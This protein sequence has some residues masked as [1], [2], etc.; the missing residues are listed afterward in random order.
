MTKWRNDP[1]LM[2]L[3]I[4]L[5]V[6]I[7][8][9]GPFGGQAKQP[10]K[11]AAPTEQAAPAESGGAQAPAPATK[12][13]LPTA[14]ATEAPAKKV[15][16]TPTSLNNLLSN[17]VK[18]VPVHVTTIYTVYE[19][20]RVQDRAHMEIDIDAAGNRHIFVYSGEED[21]QQAEIL[22][23]DKA[24]FMRGS[25][26]DQYL[27]VPMQ[28][29][30]EDWTFL[31]MYGAPWFLFFN[32]VENASKVGA[33]TVNGFSTD[34]Y[35][36]KFNMTN[37]GPLGAAAALQGGMFDYKGTG[38]IEKNSRALVKAAVSLTGKGKQDKQPTT[39]Q[40][41]FDVKKASVAPIKKPDNVFSAPMMP[42]PGS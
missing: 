24:L 9:C 28:G 8:A 13:P 3:T 41:Q 25:A 15:T 17:V 23:V 29:G 7:L 1:R 4:V 42:T 31:M 34:K 27:Q 2:L 39:I 10:T 21:E 38:W 32:D 18:L 14:K 26:E 30:E 19:G 6:P 37:L 36:V 12:K 11:A 22:V 5:I 16:A 40:L 33:E 35:E 20:K